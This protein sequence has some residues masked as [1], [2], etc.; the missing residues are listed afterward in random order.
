MF[1][2]MIDTV[3]TKGFEYP[4]EMFD[5]LEEL[6]IKTRQME[7]DFYHYA[8]KARPFVFTP[9]NKVPQEAKQTTRIE[10]APFP[11][12]SIEIAG[13]LPVSVSEEDMEGPKVITNCILCVES[14]P[15]KYV[16]FCLFEGNGVVVV[17]A[18]KGMEGIV[19][20]FVDRINKEKM[21]L[22]RTKIKVDLGKGK[23]KRRHIIR[24]VIHISPNPVSYI[25]NGTREVDWSHRFE[26]RGHWRRMPGIGKD[27]EGNYCVEGFTWVKE[28]VRGPEE[29]PLVKKQRVVHD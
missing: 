11:I 29:L 26:V 20:E 3:R 18:V 15:G 14:S 23:A 2:K 5:K 16:T 27:R 1:W 6:N 9:K 17:T 13:G 19:Q 7:E 10:G 8:E 28:H 25:S 4:K 21:G 12:F 24:E 22:E